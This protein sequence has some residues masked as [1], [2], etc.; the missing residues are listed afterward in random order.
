M[1][2][3]YNYQDAIRVAVET[4]KELMDF[5]RRAAEITQD[6]GGKKVFE[7]LANDE[8]EH[9]KHFFNLY[10]GDSLGTF[11][12]FIDGPGKAHSAMMRDLEKLLSSDVKEREAMAIALREEQ[13]LEKKLRLMASRI[14]D[15]R[16]RR[17]FD[18]MAEETRQ[19]YDVIESEY[20]HLMGMVHETDIDTYVRE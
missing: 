9:A 10:T 18:R 8:R 16:V 14:V 7:T 4:E 3:E 2:Q 13:E 12:Q 20:A 5:Y 19:H 6:P 17:V 11:E 1:P 15:P